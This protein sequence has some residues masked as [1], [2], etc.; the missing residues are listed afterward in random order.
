MDML[1]KIFPFS[2]QAKSDLKALAINVLI[3]LAAALVAGLVVGVLSW[4]PIL[5]AIIKLLGGLVG[6]YVVAGIVL[7]AL[8]YLDLLK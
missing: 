3:Y 4:V 6:I 7:T 2:F 8:D 5:G 1:K